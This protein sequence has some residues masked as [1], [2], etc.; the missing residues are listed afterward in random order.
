MRRPRPTATVEHPVPQPQ[1]VGDLDLDSPLPHL[2][3][4]VRYGTARLLVRLHG[5]PLGEVRVPLPP[6]GCPADLLAAR[7]RDH[8]GEAITRHLAR[9]GLDTGPLTAAGLP[10]ATRRG[11]LE[12]A[13]T[14]RTGPLPAITVVVATR[15]RPLSLM[16]TLRSIERLDYPHTEVLVVDSAP[17][18]D[19]A[20]RV[21]Q[22]TATGSTPTRYLRVARPGLARA[23]NV[24]LPWV[25]GEVVAFTDDDVT[26][27]P[28]WLTALAEGFAATQ[29]QCVTGLILPAELET[30]AQLWIE[31]AGGFARGFEPRTFSLGA[32]PD[33]PLFPFTPGRFGSGANMAFRTRW[34]REH[35]GFDPATGAGSPARGGDDLTA[36]LRV[37]I[38]GGTLHYQPDAVVR[39]WHR[40]DYA[41]LRRQSYGYGVGLGAHLT[42]TAAQRPALLAAMAKRVGPATM[43]L[44][45]RNSPKNRD[46]DAAFPTE[47]TWLERAGILSGPFAY[48]RSRWDL[49]RTD[50]AAGPLSQASR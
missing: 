27:D 8:L 1:H 7:V 10:S 23:H 12:C 16:R 5:R 43:Q 4:A 42:A 38:D 28:R 37:L 41:G 18:D 49:H 39:H 20:R 15:D 35:G 2:H 31:Q 11:D 3:P 24:A 29:V 21:V 34:L 25:R 44:V 47:L 9:D 17:S 46:K 19:T 22:R 48:A 30:P 13:R 45:G 14:T 50:T 40:R 26:V 6:G 33:D 32:P 36:F